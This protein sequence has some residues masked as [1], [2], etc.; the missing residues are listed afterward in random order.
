M[1]LLTPPSNQN[2]PT[3]SLAQL[4]NCYLIYLSIQFSFIIYI[5]LFQ[6]ESHQL[7]LCSYQWNNGEI[8]WFLT[9]SCIL[10]YKHNV[11]NLNIYSYFLTVTNVPHFSIVIN[12]PLAG[13]YQRFCSEDTTPSQINA[14]MNSY[15]LSLCL[16]LTAKDSLAMSVTNRM[17][18]W[19][20]IC[21]GDHHNG[22]NFLQKLHIFLKN[23]KILGKLHSAAWPWSISWLPILFM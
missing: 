18:H 19:T 10:L 22:K 13:V 2:R 8:V 12:L 3:Y 17:F 23:I 9:F 21:Q 15:R 6:I 20:T 14:K 4:C 7:W 11:I 16:L 5:T 1:S